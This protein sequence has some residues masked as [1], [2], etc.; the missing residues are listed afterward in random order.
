MKYAEYLDHL[1]YGSICFFNRPKQVTD[2]LD[3]CQ[4]EILEIL[5]GCV[6]PLG[7]EELYRSELSVRTAVDDEDELRARILSWSPCLDKLE[8]NPSIADE[9]VWVRN[10]NHIFINHCA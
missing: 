3:F 4:A 7:D 8:D 5:D 10:I 2:F 6:L 1:N 9:A